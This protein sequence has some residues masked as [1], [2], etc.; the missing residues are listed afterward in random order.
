MC[1]TAHN[2]FYGSVFMHFTSHTLLF[3]K[4]NNQL[5][6]VNFSVDF[7]LYLP[8]RQNIFNQTKHRSTWI[9]IRFISDSKMPKFM[10]EHSRSQNGSIYA[11]CL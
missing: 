3:K 8:Q 4:S 7:I 2:P 1:N 10:P 5:L 11:S 9:S 6:K